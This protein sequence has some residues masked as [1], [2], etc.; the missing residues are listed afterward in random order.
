LTTDDVA[1]HE[2]DTGLFSDWL[3]RKIT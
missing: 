3:V 1:C 2:N